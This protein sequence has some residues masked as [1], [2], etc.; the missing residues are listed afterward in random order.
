MV[1]L[2]L[3]SP[4][5]ESRDGATVLFEVMGFDANNIHHRCRSAIKGVQFDFLGALPTSAVVFVAVDTCISVESGQIQMT[6][7][8]NGRVYPRPTIVVQNALKVIET[9]AGI[10]CLG[11]GLRQMGFEIVLK[12][13]INPTLLHLAEQIHPGPTQQGDI[14]ANESIHGI[15]QQVPFSCSVAAGVSCQPHSKLGD[16]RG[17]ADPRSATLPMTLRM[18]F[19]TR[20]CL[21]ILECVEDVFKS[22]WVQKVLKTFCKLTGYRMSQGVLHLHHVWI[23]RRSRWWRI[24]SHPT[25]GRIEWE[26]FP[27]FNPPPIVADVIDDF[28]VCTKE[29]LKQ[30]ELDRYEMGKFGSIG[31]VNNLIPWRSQSKTCL[32]SCG[33]QLTGCPCGCRQYPFQDERLQNG[34]IHGHLIQ[35]STVVDTCEGKMSACRHVHPCELALLNGLSPAKAFGNQLKLA[36]CAIGQLA[37]PIQSAWLGSFILKH[38]HENLWIQNEVV[39]PKVALLQVLENLLKDRDMIFGGPSK[40]NTRN[41]PKILRAHLI[42]EKIVAFGD[43]PVKDKCEEQSLGQKKGKGGNIPNKHNVTIQTEL[44]DTW[45]C[46]YPKCPVCEPNATIPKEIQVSHEEQVKYPEAM[47]SP[48]IPF[49]VNQE[50]QKIEDEALRVAAKAAESAVAEDQLREFQKTGGVIGF[51]NTNHKKRKYTNVVEHQHQEKAKEEEIE[52]QELERNVHQETAEIRIQANVVEEKHEEKAKAEEI[53]TQKHEKTKHHETK[54]IKSHESFKKIAITVHDHRSIDSC[55]IYVKDE[56]T[57]AD[58]IRAESK[59]AP[60]DGPKTAWTNIDTPLSLESRLTEGQFVSLQ[61]YASFRQHKFSTGE[62]GFVDKFHFPMKRSEALY[63]QGPLVAIDEMEYYL[64]S[65]HFLDRVQP[66]KPMELVSQSIED[67]SSDH[68]TMQIETWIRDNMPE[69]NGRAKASAVLDQGHWNPI[70]FE[71]QQ[72]TFRAIVTQDCRFI[73]EAIEKI[74]KQ[75]GWE[76]DIHYK[77]L[78]QV[79]VA[80]C[81]FQ[82]LSWIVAVVGG[83]IGHNQLEHLT[84]HQA[85]QWR[86]MFRQFLEDSSKGSEIIHSL[87]LGGGKQDEVVKQ[88]EQLLSTHGVFAERVSERAQ[89]ISSKIPAATLRSIVSAPRAWQD[90][91]QAANSIKPPIRLILSDELQ[92]QIDKRAD[93][94]KQVGNKQHQKHMKG[95]NKEQKEFPEIHV[96]DLEIPTGVFKQSDGHMLPQITPEQ[97]GP[98]AQGI[99]LLDQSIADSTLRLPRPVTSKGLGAIVIANRQNMDQHS[100]APLRFPAMCRHTQEPIII[101]GYMYQLGEL[102]VSRHEPSHKLAVEHHEAETVRCMVY[103]DQYTQDWEQLKKQPVKTVFDLEPLLVEKSS[104]GY[105]KVIDVWDRQ[106]YSTRFE[107][108]RPDNAEIFAFSMRLISGIRETILKRSG[109]HGIYYEPRSQCGRTPA[110]EFHVTWLQQTSYQDAKYASQTAPIATSLVRHGMR[111]GLRCDS[112]EAEQIHTK[113]RPDTPLLLGTS[114]QQYNVGPLPYATTRESIQKLLKAWDWDARPLQPKGRS[115]DGSGVTWLIQAVED[116]AC[117][118]YTLQHGDVLITKTRENRPSVPDNTLN[119]VASKK[120]LEKLAKKGDDPL[121]SADPWQ[122]YHPTTSVAP[123][124]AAKAPSSATVQIAEVEARLEKKILAAVQNKDQDTSMESPV[125]DERISRLEV[126]MQQIATH[127]QQMDS[128]V[129]QMQQQIDTQGQQFNAAL[130]NKLNEQMSRIEALLLKRSRHE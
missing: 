104:D 71:L 68:Q 112:M 93:G 101:A 11:E 15:C 129:G 77:I 88:L 108:T 87:P 27:I 4:L 103:K 34:G 72:E 17:S 39:P 130:D 102:E 28:K 20:Q 85:I 109:D 100:I 44:D 125:V 61:H 23:S 36:L 12:H 10:G 90:L 97:V 54:E 42:G 120:T 91:K 8:Q 79:F 7:G 66:F 128:R 113:F 123:V 98:H 121:Q 33:N 99:I 76:V 74:G 43:Q 50:S 65:T 116:P 96:S 45:I 1:D 24:L 26:P 84:I 3:E 117:W 38:L 111:Y 35:L 70:V 47:V 32:H 21:I 67:E 64:Q 37:S 57:V 5:N 95:R 115:Q 13:D 86:K 56:S 6:L 9:C 14:C 18:S 62:E 30:L 94:I 110:M 29:E 48:T 40:P 114:K 126:Q 49:V 82:S 106:W 124:Q 75:Q 16:K 60:E 19:L 63:H 25:I 31:I 118:I 59:L 92:K 58:L 51:G 22:E 80:D 89:T 52:T 55:E 81:G 107:K 122:K 69:M 78:P 73:A 105:A 53:E 41:F 2:Q 83:S 119:V 127:Q 46:D